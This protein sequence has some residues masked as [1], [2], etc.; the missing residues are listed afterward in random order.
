M[1]TSHDNI[2]IQRAHGNIPHSPVTRF[3]S[4]KI[5]QIIMALVAWERRKSIHNPNSSSYTKKIFKMQTVKF[6]L[7]F[8]GCGVKSHHAK[9]RDF[10][11][12]F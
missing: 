9:K 10:S 3:N 4:G 1:Q 2:I 7:S 11:T 8:G 6:E 12:C 5:T